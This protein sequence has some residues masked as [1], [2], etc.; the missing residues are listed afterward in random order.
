[1]RTNPHRHPLSRDPAFGLALLATGVAIIAVVAYQEEQGRI[2]S[3]WSDTVIVLNNEPLWEGTFPVFAR[4]VPLD[5]FP[6]QEVFHS[7]FL[8]GIETA[9]FDLATLDQ[10]E[11][12]IGLDAPEPL[13][14][15]MLESG[16]L[17]KP[18]APE[19]LAGAFTRIDRFTIAGTEYTVVGRLTRSM[20]GLYFAYVM[21]YS[22][23]VPSALFSEDTTQG[24]MDPKGRERLRDEIDEKDEDHAALRD[25][26]L[27]GGN[28]SP[29]TSRHAWAVTL[30]L[31][32]VAVG[33]AIAH[34]RLF[35][36]LADR[37]I[38]P[39]RPVL[40]EIGNRPVLI[41]LVHLV[42]FG[43]FFLTMA[44]SVDYP[45]PNMWMQQIIQHVFSDGSLSYVGD[46]YA[47][48]NI[49]LASVATFANNYLMQTVFLTFLISF[50]IPFLGLFKNIA[51]FAMA[52][53]G[54]SPIWTGMAA[55][56]MYHC[57]TMT[58][59]LEAYVVAS[60]V[61]CVWP[62]RLVKG[63]VSGTFRE[64]CGESLRLFGSGLLIT[65][66]MLAGAALFEAST[67]ILLR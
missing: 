63:L 8:E 10:T 24:W 49:L 17:P 9:R 61:I 38:G 53:L 57:I 34:L 5:N 35:A 64:E 21:P 12:L 58:L 39:L 44:L 7:E 65:G 50:A 14:Q 60:F 11:W 32:L 52:G 40:R 47:S 67:L 43:P 22:D 15:L 30:G 20:P 66:I 19:V 6:N 28:R 54:M 62:I 27:L 33:G 18:G 42:L 59:E 46:A 25:I 13:F 56:F 26:E 37:R 51:S 1:M 16:R 48:G 41:G 23:S 45:L 3:A 55:I 31:L 36:L 29:A 2:E 4:R